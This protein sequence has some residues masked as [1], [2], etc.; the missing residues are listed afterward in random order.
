MKK[1]FILGTVLLNLCAFSQTKG[2]T[3][4]GKEV[5]LFDNGTWKFVNE[6]DAKTLE[7][8][9]TNDSLF[10]KS[11]DASFLMRSKKMD[12]G[13][14]F[15]P[16][17]WKVISQ[18]SSPYMEYMFHNTVNDTQ[19][20]G[21]LI[22]EKIEIPTL[23]NLKDIV[24]LNIQKSADFFRLKESEY[25]TVNGLKVLYLR[26]IAN[27]KGVDFEYIA[28]YYINDSGYCGVVAFSTQKN[29]DK[30][31]PQM[32]ELLNGISSVKKE[33]VTEVPPPPMKYE[34]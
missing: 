23:K 1:I 25:R 29:F 15:N 2:L 32:Q 26:Y 7:T 33:Q 24:I 4:D 27:A 14:Y 18:T 31:F 11:K 5:V 19:L 28:N 30:N 3:D 10:E 16:K 17:K 34:K 9:T 22:T 20:V 6:S 13:I 21:F 8:I 12:M